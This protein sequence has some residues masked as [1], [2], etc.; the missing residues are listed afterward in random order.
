MEIFVIEIKMNLYLGAEAKKA[1]A[2]A[3]WQPLEKAFIAHKNC[4]IIEADARALPLVA[5]ISEKLRAIGAT[6]VMNLETV[7]TI[8]L[9]QSATLRQVN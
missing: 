2:E 3:F 8:D 9:G 4:L 1:K 5:D 7:K 6:L